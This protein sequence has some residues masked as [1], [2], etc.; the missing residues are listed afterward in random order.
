VSRS[1]P[2]QRAAIAADFGPIDL[3]SQREVDI[4][5]EYRVGL[6]IREMRREE[7]EEE[8]QRRWEK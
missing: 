3:D 8:R 4:E 6:F 7:A 2:A 5:V 1:T